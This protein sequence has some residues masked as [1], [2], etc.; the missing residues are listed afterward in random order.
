MDERPIGSGIIETF[1]VFGSLSYDSVT[2]KMRHK[3]DTDKNLLLKKIRSSRPEV[4]L[5][6]GF[7]KICSKFTGEHPCR[8]QSNF[9]EITLRHGCSPVSLLHIFRTSFFKNTSGW[10]LLKDTKKIHCIKSVRI[11]SYSGLYFPAFGLN[12]SEYEHF[13]R[14]DQEIL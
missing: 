3:E 5:G 9:I 11:W 10:L 4:F 1:Q 12:N 13:L 6:I 8:K 14:S 7:L 2:Q